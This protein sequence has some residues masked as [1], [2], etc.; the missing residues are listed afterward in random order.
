MLAYDKT[1][2]SAVAA[3]T[4]P[5]IVATLQSIFA[6]LDDEHLI[7]ALI[8]PTRRGPK[9]HPV[10]TIWQCVI[11]RYVLG[12]DS[13]RA[14]IR[15]LE[16]NPFVAEVCGIESPDQIPHE[17][18]FSRFFKRLTAW[19]HI[20]K[21]KEV[22]RSLVRHHYAIYPGF[23]KRVALDSS[24]LKAWS[25]GGKTPKADTDAGWSIKKGTQGNHKEI[26]YGYKLHLLVD[27]EYELPIAANVSAGNVHDSQRASNVLQ[28]ARKTTGKFHPRHLMADAG[29]CG[30]KFFALVK[31]QYRAIPI[32]QIPPSYKRLR[33]ELGA[34]VNSAEYKALLKQRQA[35]ERCF[36]R[37]K[38]Q[39]ALNKIRVRGRW[40]VTVHCYL[41][42]IA[43]QAVS[44]SP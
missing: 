12:L 1:T 24:T 35:V 28:E 13:T 2:I 21:L 26:T 31:R 36:S 43:L 4:Q 16:N 25:N 30:R 19:K 6:S 23:G 33:Q 8:G 15:L 40:R 32:V 20:G 44:G 38:G 42:L 9:G 10:R 7:E 39:R 14:L 11:T 41:S 37:L 5:P 27:A 3:A 17:S 29:Y 18:T 22:S 34:A